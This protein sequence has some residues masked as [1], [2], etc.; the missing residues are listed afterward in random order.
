MPT[1]TASPSPGGG[2]VQRASWLLTGRVIGN[3]GQFV[4]YLLLARTFGASGI[5][6]YSFAFATASFLVL[7]VEFGLRDLLTRR[8]ARRP[9]DVPEIAGSVLLTQLAL[10]VLLLGVLLV[11]VRLMGYDDELALYL[12]LAFVALSIWVMGVSFC[13]FLE[14]VG[15]MHLSALAGLIH[16]GVI[17]VGGIGLILSNASLGTI[18]GAHVAAGV[19]YVAA[20]WY[21]TRRRFGP[22]QRR[23][24]PRV[25]RALFAAALPFLATSALWEIYSRV[26]IVM[27][28]VFRGDVETGLYAAAYKVIAAPLFVAELI[29]V[30]VFPTLA[31]DLATSRAETLHVFRA[32]L[33]ALTLLG[34]AGAVVLLAAGDGLQIALFGHEFE[35]SARIVR[36]MAP[37]FVIEFAMVPLWR[38]L[39]A[40]DR[41]RTLVFLRFC[42]VALNVGLNLVLIPTL[43]AIGAVGTSLFS[44]GLLVASEFVLCL[45]L[46]SSPFD[47]QGGRM[48]VTGLAAAVAG[49]VARLVLPWALAALVAVGTLAALAFGLGL[50]NV[51]EVRT[52]VRAARLSRDLRPEGSSREP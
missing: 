2:I 13:A 49:L 44:E 7:G 38:L 9:E 14:A 18:M 41:E 21:W 32:T 31:R 34:L 27:L 50:V 47:G 40:M 1:D 12:L 3:A 19:A 4:Y 5:G 6:N 20:G 17:V 10:S 33:R 45:R 37:L 11:F 36:L 39:L 30:A 48:L 15:A 22:L 51:A 28:H 43:G 46:V 25:A 8:A 35:G 23:Y 16:K 26:D 29:G 24:R 52:V 42:S